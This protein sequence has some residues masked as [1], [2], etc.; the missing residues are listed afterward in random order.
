M[1]VT[2]P[3]VLLPEEEALEDGDFGLSDCTR[4]CRDSTQRHVDVLPTAEP[5]RRAPGRSPSPLPPSSPPPEII[6]DS[7]DELFDTGFDFDA[8]TASQFDAVEAGA[9]PPKPIVVPPI[10]QPNRTVLEIDDEEDDDS[11]LMPPP[12]KRPSAKEK[13]KAKATAPSATEAAPLRKRPQ[14]HRIPSSDSS[15]A[16]PAP[17]T[18]RTTQ[19]KIIDLSL[20]DSPAVVPSRRP[21]KRAV[22]FDSSSPAVGRAKQTGAAKFRFSGTKTAAAAIDADSSVEI[23]LPK[24]LGRLRRGRATSS[25]EEDEDSALST[26]LPSPAP[27]PAKP[28]RPKRPKLNF[29]AVARTNLFDLEAINSDASSGRSEA[30]SEAYDSADSDDR[31]FVA[32]E[33]EE[34]EGEDSPGQR[35]FYLD[36]L[37]TQAPQ[38]GF[39]KYLPGA[40]R[41]S[42]G[43]W[44]GGRA[45]TPT[46]PDDV[47]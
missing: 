45:P 5:P 20:E 17:T 3:S 26:H 37:G 29:K 41:M 43:V 39:A 10:P 1:Q 14:H 2:D 18:R 8:M 19:P 24:A 47:R 27:G 12:R 28:K 22:V 40:Y 46:T 32:A 4:S 36:S 34:E 44:R 6:P 16:A 30:S 33:G 35:Q 31:R 25:D 23:I 7:D 21:S 13:G 42:K 38:M 15:S 9:L 11:I